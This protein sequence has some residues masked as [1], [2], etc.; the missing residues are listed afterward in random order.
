MKTWIRSIVIGVLAFSSSMSSADLGDEVQ[1]WFNDMNYSNITTPGVVEG[2]AGRYGTIGGVYARSPVVR[3]FVFFEVS[4]PR[5]SGGCGGIDYYMGGFTAVDK[6]QF[7]AS[8]RAIGQNAKSLFFMMGVQVISPMLSGIMEKMREFASMFNQRDM[9]SCQAAA[10]LL[11]GVWEDF[12]VEQETCITKRMVNYGENRNQAELS[13][14]SSG[15]EL[16]A[17][18]AADPENTIAFNRGNLFWFSAMQ[19]PNFSGDLLYAE[20]LMN[21]FGTVVIDTDGNSDPARV[22]RTIPRV[23]AN[24][25]KLLRTLL[26]GNS[27][28]N[29]IEI[30]R[31][32]NGTATTDEYGC[33]EIT[34][35]KVNKTTNFKGLYTH[36][37]ET[38]DIIMNKIYDDQ[39]L[40]AVE[41]GFIR[42]SKVPLLRYL[43]VIASYYERSIASHAADLDQYKIYLAKRI[44]YDRLSE[45]GQELIT[46]ASNLPDGLS[47]SDEVK[48]YIEDIQATLKILAK[49]SAEAELT[50]NEHMVYLNQI[51]LYEKMVI[52]RLSANMVNSSMWRG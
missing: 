25:D 46:L 21:L 37:S 5:F 35:G 50:I 8:L 10:E 22:Y 36:V 32:D 2:Q 4:T 30:Y 12:E 48:D 24:I 38:L 41:A 17:T 39:A 52:S 43:T 33:M 6:D 15:G 31:C 7:V 49:K 34:D 19:S 51:N 27:V 45:Q 14:S 23:E 26:E 13:C 44:M 9:D 28:Q 16:A 29:S 3:P 18:D 40:D 11:S 20:Y 1:R 42:H 47:R